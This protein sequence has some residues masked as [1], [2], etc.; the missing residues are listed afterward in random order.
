MVPGVLS[1]TLSLEQIVNGPAGEMTA[2]AAEGAGCT[3]SVVPGAVVVSK[4]P[5]SVLVTNTR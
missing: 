1:T 3:V 2:S 4:Q 5:V